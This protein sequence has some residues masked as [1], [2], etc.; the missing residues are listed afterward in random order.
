MSEKNV[1][2]I[3][4]CFVHDEKVKTNLLMAVDRL[5]RYGHDVMLVSNTPV[6]PDIISKV[7]YYLYDKRNQLFRKEYDNVQDVDFWTNYGEFTVHNLKSGLQKHG[8]SV[9]IN[10]FNS[11]DLAKSLG[12]KYFQRFETDDLYGEKSMEFIESVPSLVEEHGK[13]GL[14]YLNHSNVPSDASFHYFFCE[15]DHFNKIMTRISSED[16]YIGYLLNIQNNLD[17]RIVETYLYD[18]IVKINRESMSDLILRDGVSD[19]NLD[20]PDTVWNTVVSA[21]NLP[22]VYGGCLTGIYRVLDQR[23]NTIRYSVYSS[24]YVDLQ[25]ERKIRVILSN[26]SFFELYHNL[27]GKGAWAIN[28]LDEKPDSI[29]VYQEGNLLYT[30]SDENSNSYIQMN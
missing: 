8:L 2:S 1:I 21:S 6:T 10:L 24:N 18:H 9:L 27:S 5:K 12:Y 13:K 22:S 11:I 15:I 7:D 4:D 20:F 16:D 26:G 28:Y 23:Y 17:F 30:Q 25:I 3:I 19:M 14:F 29:E